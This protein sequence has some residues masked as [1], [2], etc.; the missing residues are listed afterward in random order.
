MTNPFNFDSICLRIG[1][2]FH[3]NLTAI[4]C[5][6][7]EMNEN[8]LDCAHHKFLIYIILVQYMYILSFLY[9]TGVISAIKHFITIH[10]NSKKYRQLLMLYSGEWTLVRNHINALVSHLNACMQLNC[11]LFSLNILNSYENHSI[12]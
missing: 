10:S 7:Q 1:W 8:M 5:V 11:L 4:F 9:N 12:D 3:K 6:F 2:A